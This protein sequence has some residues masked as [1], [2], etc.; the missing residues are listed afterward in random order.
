MQFIS[1]PR[2]LGGWAVQVHADGVAVATRGSLCP[3]VSCELHLHLI[4]AV[5][6]PCA[7]PSLQSHVNKQYCVFSSFCT[8]TGYPSPVFRK[9]IKQAAT[10]GPAA[11]GGDSNGAA[12][13]G[14]AGGHVAAGDGQQQA[15]RQQGQQQDPTPPWILTGSEDGNI[16][17]YGLNEQ[18]VRHAGPDSQL[19]MSQVAQQVD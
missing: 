19:I 17:V 10:G 5:P 11:L 8:A 18:Q 6:A 9:K 16:Y 2:R 13:D 15:G 4:L 7:P 14:T 12:A 1:Q 3:A